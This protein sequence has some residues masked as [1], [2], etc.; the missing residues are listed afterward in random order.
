M[1]GWYTSSSCCHHLEFI[2]LLAWAHLLVGICL[3]YLSLTCIR[4]RHINCRND[5]DA[6]VPLA[7][8]SPALMC[9]ASMSLANAPWT[10]TEC[11]VPRSR[12]IYRLITRAYLP[13]NLVPTIPNASSSYVI[14]KTKK[15]NRSK[16]KRRDIKIKEEKKKR[17]ENRDQCLEEP[18]C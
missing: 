18:P 8:I 12:N 3:A 13:R 16:Q 15:K 7:H 1:P 6:Y 5:F 11:L 14:K 9:I 10:I 17:K 2:L 4:S